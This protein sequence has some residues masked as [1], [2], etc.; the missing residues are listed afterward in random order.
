MLSFIIPPLSLLPPP[1]SLVPSSSQS[2]SCVVGSISGLDSGRQ[3]TVTVHIGNY[4]QIVGQI[5]LSN[6]ANV[7]F[8]VVLV[9]VG[10]LVLALVVIVLVVSFCCYTSRK[11]NSRYRLSRM[12]QGCTSKVV[13]EQIEISKLIQIHLEQKQS[14]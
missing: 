13:L 12:E 7:V 9:V 11:K 2:F 1:S 14:H 8:I 3:L 4:N 6:P 10:L 5:E